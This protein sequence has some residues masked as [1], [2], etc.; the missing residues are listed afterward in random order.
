MDTMTRNQ[1]FMENEEIITR[2]MRRNAP[3]LRALRLEWDDIYQELAVAMLNAINT[4]D[5]ARSESLRAHI[6]MKLQ[7]AVL[8]IKRRHS[9]HGMTAMGNSLSPQFYSVELAEEQGYP[10]PN[11]AYHAEDAIRE[12]RLNQAMSRLEPQERHVV[13]LYLNGESLRKKA[14]RAEFASAVEKLRRFYEAAGILLGGAI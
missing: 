1:I 9:P 2:V 13:I 8:D 10:L 4:F 7:Y 6:W 12:Q 3:L 5:P 11:R 14:Q